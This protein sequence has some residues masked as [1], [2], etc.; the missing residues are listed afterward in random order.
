[1]DDDL[2][3]RVSDSGLSRFFREEDNT[4]L[5]ITAFAGSPK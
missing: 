2:Y 3:P 4:E 1:M 5:S